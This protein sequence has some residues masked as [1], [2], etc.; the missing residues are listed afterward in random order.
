MPVFL[1]RCPLHGDNARRRGSLRGKA[2]PGNTLGSGLD[3]V[4]LHAGGV[5]VDVALP[6]QTGQLDGEWG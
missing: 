2:R 1:P 5:L 3:A 6:Q 4:D